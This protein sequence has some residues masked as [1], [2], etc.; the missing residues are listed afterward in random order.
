MSKLFKHVKVHEN[1]NIMAKS[2]IKKVFI[3]RK[4]NTYWCSNTAC[5]NKK[6]LRSKIFLRQTM[7]ANPN[8]SRSLFDG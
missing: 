3:R 5:N 4:I 2:S 6:N 1:P 7:Y 8:L